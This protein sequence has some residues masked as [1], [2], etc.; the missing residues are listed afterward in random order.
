MQNQIRS[1]KVK[2]ALPAARVVERR[3]RAAQ[4]CL[5]GFRHSFPQVILHRSH[6][7]KRGKTR[8]AQES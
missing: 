1:A 5:V 7:E 3:D 2:V 6:T 8:L 4:R